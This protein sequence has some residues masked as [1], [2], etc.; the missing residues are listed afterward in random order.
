MTNTATRWFRR[1]HARVLALLIATGLTAGLAVVMNT[2]PAF[3]LGAGQVCEFNQ[4]DGAP[5]SGGTLGHLAWAFM[6]GGTDQ[7]I[8][9]S[10]DGAMSVTNQKKK[11]WTVTGTKPELIQLF[12]GRGYNRFRCESTPVSAVGAAKAMVAQRDAMDFS[13]VF[14]NCLEDMLRIFVAYDSAL[15]SKFPPAMGF[16]LTPNDFFDSGSVYGFGPSHNL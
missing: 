16:G 12:K 4:I 3:A 14:S 13:T 7:W 15:G 6:I 9:G 5:S 11:A 10:T 8:A 2:T 1:L